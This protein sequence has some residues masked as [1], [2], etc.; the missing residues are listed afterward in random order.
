MVNNSNKK[1]VLKKGQK[2]AQMIIQ[3]FE[4]CDILEIAS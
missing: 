1:V 3:K 4:S 2:I